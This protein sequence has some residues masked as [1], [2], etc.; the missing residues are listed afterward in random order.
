MTGKKFKDADSNWGSR[1]LPVLKSMASTAK[2]WSRRF[3]ISR[4]RGSVVNDS[5][6]T[7]S[8]QVMSDLHL[9]AGQAYQTFEIT[10]CAPYL[11]LAGDVG[12]LQDYDY[13]CEFL[14]RQ[15]PRFEKVCLVLGNLEFHGLSRTE[16]LTLAA[17]LQAEPGLSQRLKVLNRT[18]F[19]LTPRITILGCTLHPYLQSQVRDTIQQEVSDFNRI[20]RWTMRE[21]NSEHRQD[22]RWLKAEL[23]RLSIEN[24]RR[25]IVIAT[26][27]APSIKPTSRSGDGKSLW[28]LDLSRNLLL[29]EAR[30]W[31]GLDNVR[32]WIF[33]HTHWNMH[34]K[35]VANLEMVSN[36][37]GHMQTRRASAPKPV[38]F[39]KTWNRREPYHDLY[40]NPN[41]VL[42]LP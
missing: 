25:I 30:T 39:W 19:D 31:L 42:T 34:K 16:G 6:P 8:V 4:H 5:G 23:E 10:P 15:C 2:R 38:G 26:H 41:K 7:I 12:R 14:Q 35:V 18:R 28:S 24:S 40:F 27:H 37:R 1:A 20:S 21:H 33:G 29:G 17:N 32:Y 36:Q 11:L 9:E 13:Y 22:V 3:C